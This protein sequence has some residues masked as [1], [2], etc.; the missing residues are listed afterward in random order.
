MTC[1]RFRL[2]ETNDY[3]P[4]RPPPSRPPPPPLRPRPPRPRPR[5]PLPPRALGRWGEFFRDCILTSTMTPI[6]SDQDGMLLCDERPEPTSS[7]SSS[8][9]SFSP[10]IG[11]T[12]SSSSSSSMSTGGRAGRPLR[13][14]VRAS[15]G[16]AAG[17]G[18]R[19]SSGRCV[20]G[21]V[22]SGDDEGDRRAP[23]SLPLH[24]A[25]IL[26][27]RQSPAD[28]DHRLRLANRRPHRRALPGGVERHR[29]SGRRRDHGHRG[30]GGVED[31][32]PPC[33]LLPLRAFLPTP[34]ARRAPPVGGSRHGVVDRRRLAI[35]YFWARYR[36]IRL[37]AIHY[38]A[39]PCRVTPCHVT[40]SLGQNRATDPRDAPAVAR[41]EP[42]AEPSRRR[43][44]RHCRRWA[45]HFDRGEAAALAAADHR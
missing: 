25:T 14:G 43:C 41:G 38:R 35:R 2:E 11:M 23:R 40:R 3:E 19:P 15:V 44:R 1:G 17:R 7:S 5:P 30:D 9:S 31:G 34:R 36:A 28:R 32:L 10:A 18:S 13:V 26:P 16:L 20:R 21:R 29:Q 27:R 42:E 22:A 12:S 8:S 39:A 45:A 6:A 4:R 24:L 37:R 33:Y